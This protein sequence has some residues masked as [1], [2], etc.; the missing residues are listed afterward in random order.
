MPPSRELICFGEDWG[1]H[2]STAQFLVQQLLGS[3]RVIWIN[4]LGWRTPR[5]TRQDFTR[6]L[7]KL[8]SAASGVQRPH[9]DLIVYTPLVMPWY[10]SAAVRRANAGLLC[11]AIRRL[12]RRHGF[13]HYSLMTTYPA[14]AEVF[15]RMSG[16]RR[17]YYCAD[18]WT[19][20]PELQPGVVRALEE[21]LLTAVDVVVTTSRALFDAKSAMHPEVVYLPHGVDIERFARAADPSTPIPNEV[22][23]LPRPMVGF[24]GL[25][26]NLIDLEIIDTI[27]RRRPDWSVV[28][29]GPTTDDVPSLPNRS[30]V[31]YLGERPHDQIP[32]YLRAL[33][34]CLMPYRLLPAL[35]YANPVKLREYLAAGKPIVSTRVPEALQFGELVQIADSSEEFILKIERCLTEAPSLRARR[36][37]SVRNQTW[38][39]RAAELAAVL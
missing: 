1:R 15:E 31:H 13:S 20:R 11:R 30:N 27:A 24:H 23:G 21:R 34:V 4:S 12:S 38:A 16:V 39:S 6:V 32:A 26:G 8:R 9:P 10:R 18:E 7:G 5:P 25:I 14:V 22:K 2:P 19:T 17:V 36:M 29:L 3:F 28:M 37:A 35:T 33:D